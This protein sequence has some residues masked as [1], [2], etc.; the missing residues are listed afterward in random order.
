MPVRELIDAAYADLDRLDEARGAVEEAI[1]SLDRGEIRVAEKVGGAWIVHEWVKRAILLY[2]RL[3]SLQT[4]HAGPLEFH[5]KIPTKT[6]LAE[7]G[8]RVVPPGTIRYGAYCE[9][10][11]W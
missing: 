9:P 5:D 8:V 1:A 4:W 6:G 2:F 10:G 7:A 3:S 11:W